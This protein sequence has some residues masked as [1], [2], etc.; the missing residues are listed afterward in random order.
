EWNDR[1]YRECLH[2]AQAIL[3]EGGRILIDASFQNESRRRL[4][5]DAGRRW[6]VRTCFIVCEADADAI[7][8]RLAHRRGDASDADWSIHEAMARR[9]EP[10][11][12]ETHALCRHLD[13]GGTP[14][15]A[16]QGALEILRE[17]GLF[18]EL[19]LVH[20]HA[21]WSKPAPRI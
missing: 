2:R 9:W 17:F 6:G 1:T 11:N 4:F 10:L 3:F 15:T 19:E 20:K 14:D 12:L 18:G 16:A 21:N 7:R 5:L 13:T 8:A